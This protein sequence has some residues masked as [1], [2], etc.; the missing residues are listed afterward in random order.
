MP[1][2]ICFCR[3]L[4]A[5]LIS[6]TSSNWLIRRS[7]DKY[8]NGGFIVFI[9]LHLVRFHPVYWLVDARLQLRSLTNRVLWYKASNFWR[10]TIA[11]NFH[12]D[13]KSKLFK[14]MLAIL[15]FLKGRY[16]KEL[17]NESTIFAVSN[18]KDKHWRLLAPYNFF[19]NILRLCLIY[20][21]D[22]NFTYIHIQIR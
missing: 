3:F 19:L 18:R 6:L 16:Y 10:I 21:R 11:K 14:W 2:I 13:D 12:I 7:H 15:R 9:M 20:L 1:P 8:R 17:Y 5:L 4:L 22:L